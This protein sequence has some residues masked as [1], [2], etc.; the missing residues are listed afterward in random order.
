AVLS[1]SGSAWA[2]GP[3]QPPVVL[4]SFM[5]ISTS[6]TDHQPGGT[7]GIPQLFASLDVLI[8]G[9]H[10]PANVQS[11]TVT[12]PDGVTTFTMTESQSDLF[13]QTTYQLNLTQAG[14]VGFP[15]GTYSFK[16]TDTG[17]GITNAADALS[18]VAPLVAATNVGITGATPISPDAFTAA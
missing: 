1:G 12:L 9:G 13:E 11:V 16:V 10:V 6:T 14:V 3:A 2:L 17:G 8:P 18:A 5:F 15:A 7:N 4:S